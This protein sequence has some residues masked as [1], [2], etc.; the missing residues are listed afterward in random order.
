MNSLNRS[1]YAL[2]VFVAATLLSGCAGNSI[3]QMPPTTTPAMDSSYAAA[4]IRQMSVSADAV[5]TYQ[6]GDMLYLQVG[7]GKKAALLGLNLEWGAA[8][9]V[10]SLGGVNYVNAYDTGREVQP[11]IYDGNQ[12][13]TCWDCKS[14]H[15]GW[16]PVQ[17]GDWHVHGSPVLSKHKTKTL[18]YTRTQPLQW[19][20]DN[21]GG[22]PNKPI[23]SDMYFDQTVTVA[24]T[25]PPAFHLHYRLYHFGTDAHY[26][27]SQEFPATFAPLAYHFLTY[28]GGTAPWTLGK[29]TRRRITQPPS[30]QFPL[31]TSE[32][33]NAYADSSGNGLTVYVPGA[34]NYVFG[35][36]VA[37]S[38]G[39]K[40][41]G[42]NYLRPGAFYTFGP[43]Q[44]LDGDI[45]LIPGSIGKARALVYNLHKRLPPADPFEPMGNTDCPA[46]KSIVSG[47]T[48]ICGWTFAH[49]G[50]VAS[51][52]IFIDGKNI[53]T[54]QYGISR[55]DVRK[56]WPHAPLRC[57]FNFAWDTIKV[58]NGKHVINVEPVDANGKQ[59]VF[60]PVPVTV[61]N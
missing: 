47:T 16:N 34:F 58:A 51:V 1:S 21:K 2:S 3:G 6:N 59:A 4:Q 29:L 12:Q 42:L 55:A 14:G 38:P 50:P 20:P 31:Y 26:L 46:A 44:S 61:K 52:D 53:G 27:G 24:S 11:S 10:V 28:Y 36:R 8:V 7:S 49:D 15:W 17:A 22:G 54:A 60:S 41:F 37:G 56:V 9:T 45:Y 40:G 30:E 39:P 25:S 57:G 35:F 48:N 5:R 19:D 23:L 43:K 33:W 32:E 13:Y 18:L